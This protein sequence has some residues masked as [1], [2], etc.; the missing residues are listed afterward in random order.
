MEPYCPPLSGRRGAVRLDFNENTAGYA[1]GLGSVYPEYEELRRRL[2]GYWGL[3]E[4]NLLLGN[5][6]GECLFVAAFTFIEPGRDRALVS[7]PTFSLIPHNLAIVGADLVEVDVTA[8]LGF[9]ERALAKVLNKGVK[10]AVFATPDN[11]T[12][13]VLPKEVLTDWC[14]R[15]P[16]TL[17]VVDEAYADYGGETLLPEAGSVPNLLVLRTF[18]KAWGMAGL[19]LG[20]V[21]GPAGLLHEMRKVRNPYS[22]SSAAVKAAT[23]MIGRAD[24]V[25]RHTEGTRGR[26]EDLAQ[27]LEERGFDVVR[28]SVGTQEENAAF[29]GCVDAFRDSNALVFDLDDT[30][31]DTSQSYDAV[32][33]ELVAARSGSAPA[34][35]ELAGLRALGG[36]NNDWD[37]AREL[38]RRRGVNLSVDAVRRQGRAL[39]LARALQ[40]EK[41]FVGTE[42]LKSLGL[43][44]RLFLYTGRPRNEYEPVWGRTL[45]PAFERVV[46]SDDYP[47]LP[48]KPAPAELLAML[49]EAGLCRGYAVGNAVDDMAAAQ[50][51]GLIPLGVATTLDTKTLRRAGAAAVLADPADIAKEFGR[52]AAPK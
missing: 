51:A 47:H 27:A 29:L 22:V 8:D 9:D 16:G 18:S 30:L 24:E 43:R 23:D 10:L 37:S 52:C 14:A 11:P 19:R 26:R 36:F 35:G 17:F 44:F 5:G 39:Y 32:V 7:R 48:G 25:R 49:G 34:L 31:V 40:V 28:G 41:L 42:V 2:S 50:G 6:L 46:C 33:A 21:A 1:G 15:F 38:L 4:E 3:A 20:V 45:T 13:A 12:G